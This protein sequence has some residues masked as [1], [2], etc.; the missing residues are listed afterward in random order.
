LSFI[1]TLYATFFFYPAISILEKIIISKLL[2]L[3]TI[4]SW[5]PVNVILVNHL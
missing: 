3:R 1:H 2:Q 5:F 4:G